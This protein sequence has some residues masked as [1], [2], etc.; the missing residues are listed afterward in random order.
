M[1]AGPMSAPIAPGLAAT[2]DG[3]AVIGVTLSNSDSPPN[4]GPVLA[5]SPSET[6]LSD[7]PLPN[8]LRIDSD[9]F[10]NF[11]LSTLPTANST[12][13]RHINSVSMSA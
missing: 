6:T 8:S 10:S 4:S 5:S 13:N 3:V 1:I 7:A 11:C 2:S 9:S 12:R